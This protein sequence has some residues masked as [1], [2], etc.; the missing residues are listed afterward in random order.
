MD[1]VKEYFESEYEKWYKETCF[2]SRTDLILENQHFKNII[3]LGV[4]AVP[5][6]LEKIKEEPSFL[7]YTLDRI[8]PG[9]VTCEGYVGIDELCKFYVDLFS[10]DNVAEQ[11]YKKYE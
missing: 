7:V 10:I 1:N 3:N 2:D 8:F 6:I 5:F 11:I 4:D 9:L